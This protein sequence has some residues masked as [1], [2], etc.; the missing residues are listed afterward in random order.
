MTEDTLQKVHAAIDESFS[1]HLERCRA[2][3]RQKSI[4]ATGEGIQETAQIV[5]SFIE[6]I[7][8]D[9]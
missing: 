2:F 6:E 1:E 4:S 8:G 7:G 9:L 5:K 3:L